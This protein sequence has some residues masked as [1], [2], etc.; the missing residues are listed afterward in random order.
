MHYTFD[1]ALVHGGV[2]RK[3]T[4]VCMHKCEYVAWPWTGSCIL[5]PSSML[6]LAVQ[7]KLC[8]LGCL[9]TMFNVCCEGTKSA[10]EESE[11]LSSCG[12]T[13]NSYNS[14]SPLGS[15]GVPS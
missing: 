2:V 6:I 14:S 7:C 5:F 13:M 15:G 4:L 11:L 3:L 9:H 8:Q 10:F 1:L 12:G